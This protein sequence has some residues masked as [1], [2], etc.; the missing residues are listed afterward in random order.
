MS[1][2]L[3]IKSSTIERGIDTAKVFLGKLITP[4]IE[5]I[6]LLAKDKVT[7]WRFKNQVKILN[8]AQKHC[9]I[10]NINPK[11]VQFKLL[12]PLIET[13]SLE[14][15]EIL[16]DKWAILLSNMV[17]SEQNIENH[18]FPYI[19]GQ[20]SKNEFLFVEQVYLYKRK[21][22]ERLGLELSILKEK[23]PRFEKDIVQKIKEVQNEIELIKKNK[24][25]E[26]PFIRENWKLK[27]KI[28]EYESEIKKLKTKAINIRLNITKAETIPDGELAEF[29]IS[30]L[31]RLGLIKETQETIAN[32]QTLEIPNEKQ[33]SQPWINNN[34]SVDVEIE[35][36]TYTDHIMTELG[37]LFTRACSEKE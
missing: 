26:T 14:E 33:F 37:E 10:H 15:D 3:N 24:K 32:S 18:V 21:R 19:L 7:L 28:K 29:E 30:N 9:E 34:V 25:D 27:D 16:Q 8:K 12:V 5:E 35:L 2:E 13:S 6:G 11:K 22:V 1:K 4:A 23:L 31:V 20:I 17:D 36:E